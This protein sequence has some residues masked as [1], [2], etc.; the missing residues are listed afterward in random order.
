MLCPFKLIKPPTIGYVKVS[1]LQ[2]KIVS[3]S[4]KT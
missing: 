3:I 1:K 2:V 4:D